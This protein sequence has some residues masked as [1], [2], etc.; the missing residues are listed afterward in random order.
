MRGLFWFVVGVSSR[1]RLLAPTP[2]RG[3]EPAPTGGMGGECAGCSGLLWGRP[4]GRDCW[5]R[6]R[7]AGWSPL[8]R[9]QIW[10]MS[11]LSR[12]AREYDQ[13]IKLQTDADSFTNHVIVVTGCHAQNAR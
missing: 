1:A 7:I 3:L 12:V 8:L 10:R 11:G 9:G 5:S 13:V 6:H 2:H 4:P